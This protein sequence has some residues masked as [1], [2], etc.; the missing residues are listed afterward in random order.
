MATGAHGLYIQSVVKPA[1][2][3]S[4][5][6]PDLATARHQILLE[7]LVM[8]KTQKLLPAISLPVP[9]VSINIIWAFVKNFK[10][11]LVH[12]I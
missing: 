6:E 5:P 2:K 11:V 8:E 12:K 7:K 3:G 10:L 1:M 4:R 9:L